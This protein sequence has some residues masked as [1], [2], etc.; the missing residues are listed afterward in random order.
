MFLI[1]NDQAKVA[2]GQEQGRPRAD[3]QPHAPLARHPPQA[4][5]FRLRH[6][7]M[8]FARARAEPVLDPGQELCRQRDF[9]QKHQRLPPAPQRFGHGLQID[10]GLARPP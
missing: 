2:E 7:R 9:R 10:L 4:A 5:A 1:D 8:P 6:P 3:H